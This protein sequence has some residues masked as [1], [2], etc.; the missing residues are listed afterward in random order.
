LHHAADRSFE[1]VGQFVHQGATLFHDLALAFG[2][3]FDFGLF[4]TGGFGKAFFFVL[5][6]ADAGFFRF[7]FE[8]ALFDAVFLEH[9]DR[10]SHFT[11]FVGAV[12]GRD[13]N[14]SIALG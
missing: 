2:F 8:A 4:A 3:G 13:F 6:L 12:Q 1:I 11:D 7:G 5:F 10:M 9:L 14:L